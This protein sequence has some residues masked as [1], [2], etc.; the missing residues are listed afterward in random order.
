VQNYLVTTLDGG[1]RVVTEPLRSVRSAAIGLW[2]GTGS[3][4]EDD[5]H[6]G[7]SHFLEHLLFKGT[8]SYSALEIAEIFDR[9]G[10]ELNAATARLHGRLR[11]GARRA[12]RHR[13]RHHDRHGLRAQPR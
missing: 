1:M 11:T 8:A 5:S 6:A 13:A 2:V 9:F 12:P 4:D 10:G 3:R 7:L